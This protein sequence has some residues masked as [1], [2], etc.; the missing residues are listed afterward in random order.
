MLI[1]DDELTFEPAA[2][3]YRL[4]A[5]RVPS[6]T[7]ALGA[8]NRAFDFVDPGILE[9]ARQFGAHVHKACDLY[10]KGVLDETDLDPALAP[11]LYQFKKFLLQ[12]KFVVVYGEHRVVNRQLK[13]AGTLDI[14]GLMPRRAQMIKAIIDLK[15]GAVPRSVGPQTA[16]YANCL[17]DSS[18]RYCKRFAL[19]LTDTSYKLIPCENIADF[20]I[21]QSCLNLYNY[22][23]KAPTYDNETS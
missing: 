21:F 8:F 23:L 4:G 10:V 6:V 12:S 16:G 1:K 9:R 20:P 22:N 15:S 5:Q 3:I 14:A 17:T 13:Y 11:R 18:W 7:Q 19:K 2:H